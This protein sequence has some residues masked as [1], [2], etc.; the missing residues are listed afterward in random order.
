M[1]FLYFFALSYA[2]SI[3]GYNE[4]VDRIS[5]QLQKT[6]KFSAVQLEKLHELQKSFKNTNHRHSRRVE[7]DLADLI[8]QRLVNAEKWNLRSKSSI[9][10]HTAYATIVNYSTIVHAVQ[11]VGFFGPGIIAE[12]YDS[13][14]TD[15]AFIIG[16]APV[17]FPFL[18]FDLSTIRWISNDI[19]RVDYTIRIS[20]GYVNGSYI[21]NN[22]EFRQT[23]YVIFDRNNSLINLGYTIQ[24]KDA[25]TMYAITAASYSPFVTCAFFIFP[26]CNVT[27]SSGY[28]YLQDTGFSSVEECIG[29]LSSL[30]ATQPCPYELRSNTTGCRALHALSSFFL[31]NVHCAHVKR[32]SGVCRDACLP[33]CANCDVNAKCVDIGSP[34]T[35][36]SP[37]YQCK[38]NNG[39]VGNGTVCTAK[40]CSNG[41]C[42]AP[43]GSYNCSTGKC[44][45]RDS[46]VHQPTATGNNLCACLP[47]NKQFWLGNVPTCL[48]PGRCIDD[49]N[50]YMCNLQQFSEVTC[51]PMENVFNPLGKCVCNYGFSGGY[52]YPCSCSAPKRRLWS[53][54]FNGFVCLNITECTVNYPDCVYPKTCNIPSGQKVGQCQ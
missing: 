22:Q 36:L 4:I 10:L 32:N 3:P 23:E 13:L 52:E 14:V 35:D 49:N 6:Y 15:L 11:G 1:L 30:P 33:A 7:M 24:D 46:F 28:N 39:Y 48:P 47:P 41:N 29:F 50:R 37:I 12:E 27:N 20:T 51:A 40:T 21:F 53:N 18:G 45:C 44:M 26:A 43:Q 5:D 42:P 25:S 16:Y 17:T 34:P 8:S 19:L 9:D 2:I 31:P 54:S 38:C